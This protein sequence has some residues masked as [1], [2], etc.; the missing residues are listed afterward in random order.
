MKELTKAE[1]QVM[2]IIWELKK[3]FVKDFL[4]KLP[5]PKPAYNTVSTIVRILEKKG[6]LGYTAYGK[7]HEYYPLIQ[8]EEYSSYYLKNFVSGY[9]G[10][11]FEKLISFFAKEKNMDIQELE[12]MLKHV[13]KDLNDAQNE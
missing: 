4:E 6:F 1:E 12:E 13:S 5:E 2:Q 10:G 9:F 7:T 8:K 11:S 3:G